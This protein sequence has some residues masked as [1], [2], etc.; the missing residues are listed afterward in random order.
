LERFIAPGHHGYQRAVDLI[1]GQ[2]LIGPF[3]S[4]VFD[5]ARKTGSPSRRYF[6]QTSAGKA[7]SASL[8]RHRRIDPHLVSSLVRADGR[9]FVPA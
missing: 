7:L 2:T 4:P 5:R 9:S 8:L 6:S 1:S 3:G